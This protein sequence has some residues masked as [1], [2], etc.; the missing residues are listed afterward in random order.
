MLSTL[1][2]QQLKLPAV[3]CSQRLL[4]TGFDVTSSLHISLQ[5]SDTGIRQVFICLS[6]THANTMDTLEEYIW[7]VDFSHN[8]LDIR[9]YQFEPFQTITEEF[10]GVSQSEKYVELTLTRSDIE[11]TS[12]R[13]VNT[14]W[15]CVY[16][17][18]YLYFLKTLNMNDSTIL[19]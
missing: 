12:N 15:Q 17:C 7:D 8:N 6:F 16:G 14:D 9:P 3:S 10:K 19:S 11:E 2:K 13:L 5:L 1:T 18:F 4:T